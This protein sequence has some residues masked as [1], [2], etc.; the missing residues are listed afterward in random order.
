MMDRFTGVTRRTVLQAAAV[1]PGAAALGWPLATLALAA[2]KVDIAAA[3]KE[4]KVVLYTSAPVKAAE[5]VAKAFEK[6]YGIKVELFR[7]GGTEVLR[8]FMME[9][10]VG[11]KGADV[12]VSSD[13]GATIDLANKGSFIPFVPKDADKIREGLNDEKGRFIAQRVSIITNYARSDLYP[14]EKMPQTWE[15]LLKPE[16]KGKLVMTDPSFSSLAL[17]VA[18]MNVKNHGWEFYEGLRKNEILVVRGN[19]IA[20]TMVKSGERPI[21]AGVDSQYANEARMAGFKIHSLPPKDGTFAIPS[22]TAVVKDCA[23]PN[24][25]KLLAEYTISK[26]AEMLWPKEGVYAARADLDPPEGAPRIADIKLSPLDYHYVNDQ[27]AAVKKK[28][29]EIF[30]S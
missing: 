9:Q 12:L 16:F 1:L 7:T 22:I 28:F 13:P 20:L 30:S 15:D 23:H 6:E 19:Q 29:S 18:A 8:R 5:A 14:L 17:V 21:A 2:D 11:H 24:A 3:K 25:A 26:E 10:Q 27:A 4:G